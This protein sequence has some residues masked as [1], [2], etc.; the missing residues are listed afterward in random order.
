MGPKVNFSGKFFI[1]LRLG[2]GLRV[3]SSLNLGLVRL[4]GFRVRVKGQG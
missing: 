4:L 3:T 1:G 2:S